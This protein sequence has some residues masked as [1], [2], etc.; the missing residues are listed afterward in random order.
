MNILFV[1]G[2]NLVIK[3]GISTLIPE[4]L[5]NSG[6]SVDNVYNI[7]VG[8]TPCLFGLENLTLFKKKQIDL[9][10]IEYGINDLPLF[11]NDR[12]LWEQAFTS[13]LTSLKSKYPSAHIVTILLGRQK[14]RFW[15]NQQRM[16]NKMKTLSDRSGALVVDIDTLLKEK[17]AVAGGFEKF[18]LDESHYSSPGVT[19]YISE[20]VVSEYLLSQLVGFFDKK[21]SASSKDKKL[22]VYGLPGAVECYENSR[23]HKQTTVLEKNESVALYVKGAPVAISFISANDS[24]SLLLES[25]F[26]NK[27]INTKRKKATLGKFSFILKQ[28][29][30]YGLIGKDVKSDQKTKVTLTALD[31]NSDKWDDAIMQRTYGMEP[32]GPESKC[33]FLSHLSS[34]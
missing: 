25:E 27:I 34:F 29:P 18:Y 22:N 26:G 4:C 17:A 24:C 15:N 3:Q 19:R 31:K 1:G 20:V 16:H 6:I 7:A 2:S 30:L 8:A 21:T 32:S 10:F 12:V 33:L 11:A 23:F 5:R 28:I 14:E 9:V 13:L